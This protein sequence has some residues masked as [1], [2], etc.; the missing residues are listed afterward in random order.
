MLVSR[1][2]WLNSV[3]GLGDTTESFLIPSITRDNCILAPRVISG[4]SAL[5]MADVRSSRHFPSIFSPANTQKQN[6]SPQEI[7][8]GKS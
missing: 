8:F 4:N 3:G 6:E 7:R 2:K 5:S 1:Y